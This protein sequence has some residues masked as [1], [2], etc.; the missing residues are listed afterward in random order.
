MTLYWSRWNKA[1]HRDL[2]YFFFAM[3]VIYAFSGIAINHLKDWNPN[4]RIIHRQFGVNLPN[5]PAKIDQNAINGLLENIVEKEMYKKHY[6]PTEQQ[7]K[8]FLEGG[9]LEVNL[10]TGNASLEILKPRPVLKAFNFLHYNPGKTWTYFS[11]LYAMALLLMA[12]SGL[13][14]LRG[15]NGIT[16][17]GAILTGAGIL[18]PALYLIFFYR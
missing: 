11:D 1:I 7:L 8:V 17:R 3:T 15:K 5:D 6:F 16:R 2:G 4:Y 10:E 14:I 9:T 13:F 12:F 18:L